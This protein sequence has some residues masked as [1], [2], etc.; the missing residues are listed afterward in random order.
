MGCS[1]ATQVGISNDVSLEFRS[2]YHLG[3]K[4]GEGSFAQVREC[5]RRT[6]TAEKEKS[7][8]LAVKVMD[9]TQMKPSVVKNEIDV[10]QK[11]SENKNIVGLV[12]SFF[13]AKAGYIVMEKCEA[14]VLE[15][16]DNTEFV[17]EGNLSCIFRQMLLGIGYVHSMSVVHRDIKP[18][19]FLLGGIDGKVVKLADFGLSAMLP[20]NGK[21]TGVNGTPPYMSPEMLH[22]VPYDTKS[23]IWSFGATAYTLLFGEFPYMPKIFKPDEMKQAIKKGSPK[24]KF[25]AAEG[26]TELIGQES[27]DFVKMLLNRKWQDRPS[28][29]EALEHSFMKAEISAGTSSASIQPLIRKARKRT[30]DFEKKHNPIVQRQLSDLL[31]KLA[32]SHGAFTEKRSFSGDNLGTILEDEVADNKACVTGVPIMNVDETLPS[33]ISNDVEV[34][35]KKKKDRSKFSTN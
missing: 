17:S 11:V 15:R 16:L 29:D 21:L 1:C 13:D 4:I 6:D 27:T 22:S 33:L 3:K 30:H 5:W 14:S 32:K 31:D 2:R 26:P 7:P 10:W 20:K 28:A 19:N 34:I 12:D 8:D 25:Q 23:D 24:P 35:K 18:T 9:V